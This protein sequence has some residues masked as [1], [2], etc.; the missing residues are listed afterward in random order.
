MFL[1]YFSS[2]YCSWRTAFNGNVLDIHK[3]TFLIKL[4]LL[5]SGAANLYPTSRKKQTCNALDELE[6]TSCCNNIELGV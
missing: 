1:F 5:E 4:S 3:L 6:G 2:I